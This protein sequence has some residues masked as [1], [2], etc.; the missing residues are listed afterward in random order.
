MNIETNPGFADVPF[1][2]LNEETALRAPDEPGEI[3]LFDTHNNNSELML[4]SRSIR[5]DLLKR[6]AQDNAGTRVGWRT[7]ASLTEL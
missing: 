5:R 6:L 2:D 7:G 4:D 1:Y 3:W